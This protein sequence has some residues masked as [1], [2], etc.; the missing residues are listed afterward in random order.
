M[1]KLLEIISKVFNWIPN[2]REYYRNR[3]EKIKREMDDL[4]K[5]GLDGGRATRYERL[6]RELRK[7]REKSKN[8]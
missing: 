8:G 6:A 7:Y 1:N 4:Q 5:Q 2:K 3:I